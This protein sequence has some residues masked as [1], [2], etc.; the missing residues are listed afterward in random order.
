VQFS[1][2]INKLRSDLEKQLK[3]LHDELLKSK[4]VKK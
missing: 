3:E 4:A 1:D 2:G